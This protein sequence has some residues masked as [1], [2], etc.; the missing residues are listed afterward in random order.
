MRCPWPLQF[1]LYQ[2]N[3]TRTWYI[4]IPPKSAIEIQSGICGCCI[5]LL[6]DDHSPKETGKDNFLLNVT[7][8][9]VRAG[10]SSYAKTRHMH[11]VA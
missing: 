5:Q 6:T 10:G 8:M 9:S 2:R 11:P 3:T 7:K 1:L 4:N